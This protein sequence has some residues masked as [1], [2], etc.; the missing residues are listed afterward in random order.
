M[1]W[2]AGAVAGVV[3]GALVITLLLL[4]LFARWYTWR[5]ANRVNPVIPRVAL[6][7]NEYAGEW[8]E[9]ASYPTWF[10]KGCSHTTARYVPEGDTLKIINRCFRRGHWEEAVGRAY[11]TDFEGV[12]AVEFFPGLYGNYTVTYRDPQTAIVTNP[13]RST[14]WILSRKPRISGKKKTSLLRWLQTHHF[15]TDR[16][17]FSEPHALTS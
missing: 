15:N 8:H 14:L 7:V 4:Y 17:T 13:D 5:R 3:V 10:E 9:L 1:T 6:D 2:S 11:P 12:L 16:L